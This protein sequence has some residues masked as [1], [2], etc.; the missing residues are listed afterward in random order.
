MQF[1][2]FTAYNHGLGNML[3]MINGIWLK[4]NT[5]HS[6]SSICKSSLSEGERAKYCSSATEQEIVQGALQVED[7]EDHVFCFFRN[8]NNQNIDE[9]VIDAKSNPIAGDH[10]DLNNS[11]DLDK[12]AKTLQN[13][14][15][16]K[17]ENKLTRTDNK[18]KCLQ[19]PGRMDWKWIEHRSHRKN[20]LM[21]FIIPYQVL[22]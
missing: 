3:N 17:L 14:L 21:T 4:K 12:E 10:I 15:K 11:L 18:K 7:A 1:H 16:N 5:L 19:I 20:V 9:I 2:L 8:I 13:Q 6:S 22:F